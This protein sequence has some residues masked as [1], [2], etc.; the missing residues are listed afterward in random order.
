MPRAVPRLCSRAVSFR[1]VTPQEDPGDGRTLEGY[2]AVFDAPTEINSWEGAFTEKVIRGAFRKTLRERTP[3]L[4]FDHGR[5]AR[6]GSVPI[7]AIS[8]IR[9][10]ETGL[11]V[12]ARLFDN[13]V[14]EPIRQAIEGGAIDGMSF[15]FEV[16]RDEWRDADGKL[17]KSDDLMDRL[18]HNTDP[19]QLVRT[20]KEVKL[21]E[22]GPVVFPA[23]E[24]TSVGVR[25]ILANLDE[26]DRERLVAELRDSLR[27]EPGQEHDDQAKSA[28]DLAR[29]QADEPP[30]PEPDPSPGPEP[31]PEPSAAPVRAKTNTTPKEGKTMGP[32]DDTR[33]T[34]E[35][36]AAR[37]DEI[38][39][40]LQEIDT[41]FNGSELPE[42]V[43]TEWRSL[44]EEDDQHTRA[45]QAAEE[46]RAALEQRVERGDTGR[47]RPSQYA[48]RRTGVRK[49]DN[50]YDLA[51]IRNEARSMDELGGL[52][53][54]HA[55]R[56]VE[57]ARFPGVEDR[58]AA[59]AQV[60]KL[61]TSVDDES[62]TLARRIL[63][64]GSPVYDR[65]FGKVVKSLSTM[66]LT[67]E[68]S[69]ALTVG[70]DASG[71]FAVPF[72]LDPTVILTGGGYIN[73]LRRLARVVQ[74][75]GKEWQGITSAGI[76]VSRDAEAEEVSDD[77]PTF[78]QPTVRP[79]RVQG[80]VPFS[81]EID[82]DWAS[83]RSE[84]T[85]MLADAKE[86]EEASSFILG[87]GTGLE[88][89]GL[90]GSMDAGSVV[91]VG[92]S[93]TSSDLYDLEEALPPRFRARAAWMA[94]RSVF[95]TV[96]QLGSATDGGDLWV[97]LGQGLP[98]ELIGYPAYE[99]S[100]MATD[101]TTVGS[102]Y[103]VFG[104]F[105]KFLIVD[106]VGMSIE[107]VPHL[108][109]ANRRPTGQRGIYA[110][111]RNNSMVLVP[112]AFRVAAASA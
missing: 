22:A 14:V 23:Y 89:G 94:N 36:R 78:A 86:E 104:D 13:Q 68:E 97:R 3:V 62:G 34:V 1:A 18:M 109:G 84:I 53:R 46:R 59:Q 56:A 79:T 75:T 12:S 70:T 38:R 28:Y 15:R 30:S 50:I 106:R 33:M 101:M 58:S 10:D 71:G 82:Q 85:S 95:N 77:S 11:F 83:L 54:D 52:Y 40:R 67:T 60:E 16:L 55:L 90:V 69:R 74:I 51:A 6:T 41:E 21:F 57:A 45:I 37:Q 98:P 47:E 20:I 63:A 92:A 108:F 42:E 24:A 96:R 91:N 76:T 44:L 32:Q 80:F 43:D 73:P 107:L 112:G 65:A 66:G 35:E 88:P 2:A 8:D 31:T 93:L 64:T 25:S 102:R 9:E 103:L 48:P 100:T 19:A 27:H 29:D 111:W 5:D 72:Q 49:A 99:V 110:I 87:D 61:L 39:S 105:S 81:I 7:G 17:V 4:Q 26:S